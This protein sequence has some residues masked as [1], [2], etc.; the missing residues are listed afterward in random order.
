[1]EKRLESTTTTTTSSNGRKA[2]KHRTTTSGVPPSSC[3]AAAKTSTLSLHAVPVR[4]GDGD[5]ESGGDSGEE[6]LPLQRRNSIHNV[7]YVDVND[8]ETRSRM[9]RYKEERRSLL[10]ARYKAEDYL[11]SDFGGGSRKKKLSAGGSSQVRVVVGSEITLIR[12]RLFKDTGK[13]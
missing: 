10:R 13:L 8:P 9:E 3:R 6:S 1:M 7:P 2:A 5:A 12:I 4:A 11:S